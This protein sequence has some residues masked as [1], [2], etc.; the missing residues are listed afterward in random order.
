MSQRYTTHQMIDPVVGRRMLNAC[1][2]LAGLGISTFQMLV[3]S[4]AW[5][6]SPRAAVPACMASAWVISSLFGARLRHDVRLWGSSLPICALVWLGGT[7][8]VS[9]HI[10]LLPPA[11]VHLCALAVVALL[12]RTIST[13]WLSQRPLWSPVGERTTL[14]RGLVSTTAGLFVV[15]ILPRWSGLVGLVCLIPLLALDFW[16]AARCPLPRA[17]SVLDDWVG[18]YWNMNRWQLQLQ[19]RGVGRNWSSLAR[20]SMDAKQYLHLT[21]LASS[22]AVIMGGIWGAVPTPFASG[23][24]AT[25]A[26]GTLGWL[27][28]GQ[29]GAL[30][31][32]AY[33]FSTARGVIG[34]PNRLL[35]ESWRSRA[36]SLA[37]M[38]LFIMGVSLI[39]LVPPFL[40]APWWLALSL[41]SYT[42][43][44]SVWG[45]FLPRLR[46]NPSMLL[47]AQRH[48]MSG[49]G[50][51]DAVQ[52]A[53]GRAQEERITRILA[54]VEG[55][56]IAVI[57]PAVG[58]LIDLF[59]SVDAV[60]IIVGLFFVL[61]LALS[62]L[63]SGLLPGLQHNRSQTSPIDLRGRVGNSWKFGYRS[64]W[65]AY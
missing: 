55:I 40:Q 7:R 42:F 59:G 4:Q 13:A 48:L 22:T 3:L 64:L 43:A 56:L 28:A 1:W 32:G 36:L 41:A 2:F 11:L 26:L 45:I 27:L 37:V 50:Q 29:I 16:P 6:V 49:Q 5:D 15:W 30:A 47:F 51:L 33:C 63:V 61:L 23:L 19:E 53:H 62:L 25:H 54:T 35:P 20:R 18:R 65:L 60:L 46:S 9:W 34:L 8:F 57:T 31:I 14:A 21:L 52:I 17:G 10:P 39:A 58:R 44:G 24:V 12:L 38:M